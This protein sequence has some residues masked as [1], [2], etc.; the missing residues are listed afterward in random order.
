MPWIL[1]SL[2]M[3]QKAI[4]MIKKLPSDR[5]YMMICTTCSREKEF[6]VLG[7]KE[8]LVLAKSQ[9]WRQYCREGTWENYCPV[10][11]RE[12]AANQANNRN[13]KKDPSPSTLKSGYPCPKCEEETGQQGVVMYDKESEK[14]VCFHHECFFGDW[15]IEA[16]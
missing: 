5:G 3:P 4:D 7:W 11:V 12:W 6:T 15:H 9:G 8:L 16:R 10:C 2:A 14:K 13:Q 1:P